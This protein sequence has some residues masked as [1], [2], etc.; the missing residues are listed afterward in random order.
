[1]AKLIYDYL[2]INKWSRPGN[3]MKAVK[4]IVVHWVA[5]PMTKAKQNRDFFESRKDGLKNFGSAHEIID[6]NGDILVCLPSNEWAYHVGSSKPYMKDALTR[7]S[8][9]P[10]NCTYGIECTH[11]EW[12]GKMTDATYETLVKRCA[13]LCIKWKLDPLRDIWLHKEVVGWKDCHRWF[14]D[15]PAEWALFKQRVKDRVSPPKVVKKMEVTTANAIISYLKKAYA[16]ATTK[17]EKVAIGKY[18]DE[19]R[20][21]S[22]QAPQNK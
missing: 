7:L 10:N 2:T 14:V 11:T 22:G 18:A 13:D 15:H 19:L 17:E 20:V 12:S 4:G 3:K 16:E 5:N 1:M 6:L 21:L 9:Y 8:D